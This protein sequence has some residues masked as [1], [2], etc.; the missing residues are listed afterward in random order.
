MAIYTSKDLPRVV[1][2]IKAAIAENNLN[3]SDFDITVDEAKTKVRVETHSADNGG[4]IV[5]VFASWDLDNLVTRLEGW[6]K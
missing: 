2:Y 4:F 6:G 5:N 3:L 1:G